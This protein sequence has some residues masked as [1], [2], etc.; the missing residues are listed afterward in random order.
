MTFDRQ[1]VSWHPNHRSLHRGVKRLIETLP[2]DHPTPLT[3]YGL[4]TVS[5]GH[6][7]IGPV[8]ALLARLD[9]AL[10]AFARPGAQGIPAFVADIAQ[11][12]TAL[13]A[14]RRHA[15]QLVWFRWLYVAFS[16]YMWVNEWA[17]IAPLGA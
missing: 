14:M 11:Y 8:A 2:P 16:R 12:R 4:V 6:K 9:L 1:G 5:L 13:R 17:R 10:N 7:Y 3:A 15:S